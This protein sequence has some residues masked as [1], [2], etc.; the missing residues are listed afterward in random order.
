MLTITDRV[1][2]VETD[3]MGV[4]HHTNYLRWFEMGRVEY[5]RQCG[6]DLNEMQKD[7]YLFPITD[8]TC[9]YK[10][11]AHFDDE[12]EVQTTLTA[13][14]RAKIVFSYSVVRKKDGTIFVT[15]TSQ[16]VFTTLEGKVA[17]IPEPY[18]SKI[19]NLFHQEKELEEC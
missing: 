10:N 8:V 16:N 3:L 5:L 15:G 2:F 9:K 14:S 13:F 4:V 6:I 1:R 19:N 12:Y 17:R 18:F 7:G 11:S